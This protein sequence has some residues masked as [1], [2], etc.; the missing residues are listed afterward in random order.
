MPDSKGLGLEITIR[1][2]C[3]TIGVQHASNAAVGPSLP[4]I[5]IGGHIPGIAALEVTARMRSETATTCLPAA[6]ISDIT[7]LA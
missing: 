5:V 3:A 2:R 1:H 4:L 7:R 6:L